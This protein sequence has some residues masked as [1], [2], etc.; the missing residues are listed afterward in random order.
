MPRTQT[1]LFRC[2]RS[3]YPSHGPLRFI[4]SHSRFALAS[5]MRKTK[6]LRRRLAWYCFVLYEIQTFESVDKI[7]HNEHSNWTSLEALPHGTICKEK[8]ASQNQK[9][10][11]S[12][13]NFSFHTL[14]KVVF[15]A[16]NIPKVL[17]DKVLTDT[18][19]LHNS[20][21]TYRSLLSHDLLAVL[22]LAVLRVHLLRQLMLE[23]NG[24]EET[25]S[26]KPCSCTVYRA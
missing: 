21:V 23:S 25:P 2:A 24:F 17:L 15:K 9:W 26:G 3:L 19:G 1:S 6:R 11:F 13:I 14:F 22:W 4:T 8:L 20:L 16:L 18:T 5:A 12:H 7:L 10:D